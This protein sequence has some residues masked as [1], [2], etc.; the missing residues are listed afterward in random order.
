MN[1][2]DQLV[3]CISVMCKKCRHIYYYPPNTDV[4]PKL[5]PHCGVEL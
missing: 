1:I 2:E 5:C 3:P 4:P